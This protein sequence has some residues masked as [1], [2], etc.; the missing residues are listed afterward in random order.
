MTEDETVQDKRRQHFL[1]HVF[2]MDQEAN[3]MPAG[4][5]D[6]LLQRLKCMFIKE[7]ERRNNGTGNVD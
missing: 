1:F 5:A 7:K 3:P 2:K 6:A 4:R